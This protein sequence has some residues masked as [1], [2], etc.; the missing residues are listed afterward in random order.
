MSNKIPYF[1]H[2]NVINFKSDLHDFY[3]IVD[4]VMVNS[5]NL[6][7]IDLSHNNFSLLTEVFFMIFKFYS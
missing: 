6:R 4:Q 5:Y 3:N 2:F 1:N 7:W